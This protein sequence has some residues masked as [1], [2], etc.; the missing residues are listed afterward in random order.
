MS[1]LGGL[2]ALVPALTT[3]LRSATEWTRERIDRLDAVARAIEAEFKE[4]KDELDGKIY[5][6]RDDLG[7]RSTTTF[8]RG[9]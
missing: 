1:L 3:L 6:A 4:A 5:Q 9:R 8:I 7:R 2:S